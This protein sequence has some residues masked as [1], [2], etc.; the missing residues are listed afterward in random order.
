MVHI[1][2][3]TSPLLGIISV[4]DRLI[5]IDDVNITKMS[6]QEVMKLM[7]KKSKQKERK[8]TYLKNEVKSKRKINARRLSEI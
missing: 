3:E 5:S 4:G 6:V 8:I 1:I 7:A 2:R